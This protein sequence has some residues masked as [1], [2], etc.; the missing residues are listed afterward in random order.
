[1]RAALTYPASKLPKTSL[2]L[3]AFVKMKLEQLSSV[4][5]FLGCC[6][7]FMDS[8]EVMNVKKFRIPTTKHFFKGGNCETFKGVNV[9]VYWWWMQ[10]NGAW[11]SWIGGDANLLMLL[12]NFCVASLV[13]QCFESCVSWTPFCIFSFIYVSHAVVSGTYTSVAVS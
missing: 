3:N 13:F 1:M 11:K 5:N 8:H 9:V 2:R 4:L 10:R 7:C 6:L 12:P